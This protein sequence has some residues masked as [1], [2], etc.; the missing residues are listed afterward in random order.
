MDRQERRRQ[1]ADARR[2][3]AAEPQP[4]ALT[5][6]GT[7]QDVSARAVTTIGKS[8]TTS[9]TRGMAAQEH[10]LVV[11]DEPG[12]RKL[13]QQYL[14]Q[15][16]YRVSTAANGEAMLRA[17][18]DAERAGDRP[19]DAV[20]LDLVMPGE[21][22]LSLM[23]RLRQAHDVA[24]IILTLKSEATD[25]VEGLERGADDYV[26]K[27]FN[28]REL[29]ARLKSVLRRVKA[30][31]AEATSRTG[32]ALAETVRFDG[33]YLELTT[34]ELT[35]PEGERVPLSPGEF[36]LLAA[37]VRNPKRLLTR[38]RLLS[39]SRNREWTPFDRSID[40]QIGRLRRKI[41][42]DPSQP[43]LIKTVRGAGYLFTAAVERA[44]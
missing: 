26:T 35:S 24:I 14:S 39:L 25:R 10:I 21:D 18:E 28:L 7:P 12:I 36:E 15:Q 11:D 5:G 44:D 32:P 43:T 6:L 9:G 1:K 13:L 8:A 41:E 23:R 22:G 19:V 42:A 2:T 4:A 34:R 3:A 16:G 27:P 17:L 29:L 38:D 40:V 31:G 37:F 33:W 20:I 30:A